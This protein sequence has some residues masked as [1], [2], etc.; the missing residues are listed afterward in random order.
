M[1]IN[2]Y[3]MVKF[4]FVKLVSVIFSLSLDIPAHYFWSY[5]GTAP[6][7]FVGGII[8]FYFRFKYVVK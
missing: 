5:F 4:D 3:R 1:V 2:L 6:V 7:L 8:I